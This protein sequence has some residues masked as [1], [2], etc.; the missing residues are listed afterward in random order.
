MANREG[1]VLVIGATGQL[2]SALVRLR[3]NCL[4]V[5]AGLSGR[6]LARS[7]PRCSFAPPQPRHQQSWR[8]CTRPI[9]MSRGSGLLEPAAGPPAVSTISLV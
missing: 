7:L 1:P 5:A 6:L 2:G 8:P 4:S 9:P 3:A